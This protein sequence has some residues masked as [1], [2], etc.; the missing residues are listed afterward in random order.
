[1]VFERRRRPSGC[2]VDGGAKVCK[3]ACPAAE[4]KWLGGRAAASKWLGGW[5]AGAL[6]VEWICIRRWERESQRGQREA[7]F[8]W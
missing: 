2:A 4:S 5:A 7:C 6:T 8:G 3:H 1:M